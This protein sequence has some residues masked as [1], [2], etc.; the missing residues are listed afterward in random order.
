MNKNLKR[1]IFLLSLLSLI[2]SLI[3]FYNTGVYLDESGAHAE[4]LHGGKWGLNLAWIR[5]LI[6]FVLT[7]VSGIALHN[8]DYKE[9][10][11]NPNKFAGGVKLLLDSLFV[12]SILFLVY[13]PFFINSPLDIYKYLPLAPGMYLIIILTDLAI[14]YVLY[15]LRKI[16]KT[17]ALGTPF[18]YNNA[19]SLKRMALASFSLALVFALKLFVFQTILTFVML[20]V[21]IICGCF[22]L[23]LSALFRQAAQVKE[24]NDLTI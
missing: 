23:T 19:I 24:E 13:I 6:L 10:S 2:V 22:A 8:D 20:L 9:S 1:M 3:L 21:L 11:I 4:D 18:T 17:I 12:L 16:Y 14:M 7:L 5:L 15:E